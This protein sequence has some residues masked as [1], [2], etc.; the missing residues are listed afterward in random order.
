MNLGKEIALE[1]LENALKAS[2]SLIQDDPEFLG[3]VV[4][5]ICTE[6]G[7]DQLASMYIA[8]RIKKAVKKK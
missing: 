4:G 8:N 7:L 5:T 2:L 6:F 1:R 3:K